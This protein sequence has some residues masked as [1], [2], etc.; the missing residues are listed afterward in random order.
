MR[1]F[2]L[3]LSADGALHHRLAE[4]DS[5]AVA[6]VGPSSTPRLEQPVSRASAVPLGQSSKSKAEK[7]CHR[8]IIRVGQKLL[9]Q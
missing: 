1:P 5:E 7:Q 6:S 2:I 4:P 9:P 3:R 8:Q